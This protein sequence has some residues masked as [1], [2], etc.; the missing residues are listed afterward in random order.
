MNAED[1]KQNRFHASLA[2]Y[3]KSDL[4]GEVSKSLGVKPSRSGK[5][6]DYFFWIYSTQDIFPADNIEWHLL[7][8]KSTF[9]SQTQD[10]ARLVD[11]GMQVR[12]W[13]YFGYGGYNGGINGS[14]VLSN[15][16]ID[17][18]SSFRGDIYVD[19]WS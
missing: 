13:I 10:L 5:K 12:I 17:W 3:S 11:D 9:L 6:N 2:V 19:V 16:I 7:H 14:F 1:E 18:I 15:E 4:I 8:L